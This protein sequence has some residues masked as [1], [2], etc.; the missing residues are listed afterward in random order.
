MLRSGV[1]YN[2]EYQADSVGELIDSAIRPPLDYKSGLIAQVPK[3]LK[4]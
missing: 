2:S 3:G 4:S 1:G